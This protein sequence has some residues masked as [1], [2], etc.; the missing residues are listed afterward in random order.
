VTLLDI[1]VFVGRHAGEEVEF[2]SRCGMTSRHDGEDWLIRLENLQVQSK[3]TEDD[4]F[5][6]RANVVDVTFS[7]DGVMEV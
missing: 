3:D 2:R 6:P 1:D 7:P 5:I 4:A